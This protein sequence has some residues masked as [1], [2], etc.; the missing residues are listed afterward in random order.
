MTRNR[1]YG[2]ICLAA[3]LSLALLS[4]GCSKSGKN[5]LSETRKVFGTDVTITIFD[6]GFKSDNAK[7]LFDDAF[8]IMADWQ[9]KTLD[10]GA[11]NQ[12]AGISKGAGT[13]SIPVDA[14]VFEMLMKALRL[15]DQTGKVF[16]IRYGPMLDAW[17]FDGKPHV[18]AKAEL[19][20][21][22]PLVSDGGM[23]IAGNSILLAKKGMRFDVREIA[24]GQ[25][26][27]MAAAR[28]A[29]RGIRTASICSP[30]VCRTMGDL[31]DGRGFKWVIA[32]PLHP[33]QSWA[34]VWVPVG[35]TAYASAS[36]GEF[37]A[38]GKTYSAMLDPRTGMPVNQCAGAVVQAPDAATA[39]ALAYSLYVAG[40]PDGFDSNGKAAIGGSVIV[41]DDAG[42]YKTTQTGSLSDHFELSK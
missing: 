31:P 4:S 22:K 16:D 40:S 21:L 42:Q 1:V 23:F 26:F 3:I 34:T 36:E 14:P 9:K 5:G 12:V 35:G 19:D 25:A 37:K 30:H 28:L 38:D 7:A 13:Q 18:P 8:G 24:V 15:Y 41:H 2:A 39:Q 11:D 33:D 29:E 17:G 10:P 27:D 32:D 20:S 6:P